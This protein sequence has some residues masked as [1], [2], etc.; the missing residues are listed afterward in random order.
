MND[1]SKTF[2]LE[3]S[4]D[5]SKS[6]SSRASADGP[7]PSDSPAGQ[8]T[9]QFGLA[10]VPVSRFRA[11][12]ADKAM[13]INDISGPLF[14]ASSPSAAL[15]RFLE[16]RLRARLGANGSPLYVLTWSAVDMPSGVPILRLRAAAHRTSGSGSSGW[17]TAEQRKAK[18]P[19]ATGWPSPTSLSPATGEYNEAGDS[20]NLRKIRLLAGWPTPQASAG[21][22]EPAGK[23]GRKL[24]TVA[25]LTGWPT[26][27]T[28]SG[29]RSTSIEKMDA[30]GRTA[31]RTE[32]HGEP[33]ARGQVR[34]L[35]DTESGEA[36]STAAGRLHSEP[37]DGGWMD[38]P[39]PK[40]RQPDQTHEREHGAGDRQAGQGG[41]PSDR[42]LSVWE[43][44][45]L[46][47]CADEKTRVTQPGLCPLAHGVPNRVGRLRAY[48]NAIVPPLAAEFIRAYTAGQA[49]P[50]SVNTFR[51]L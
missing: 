38:N 50:R 9:D 46:I 6:T 8:T 33:G 18:W 15:Q 20:C 13:P 37:A 19:L 29:G 43:E 22:P 7:T 5:T 4:P 44:T 42:R 10:P 49:Q 27:C 40:R 51:S 3:S 11:R 24:S 32:A 48:G 14:T 30:T 34:G 16:S 45:E 41:V 17:P 47:P 26:P 21:G 25:T 2:N 39:S 35:A 36:H 28:P 23:T 1:P 12:D 31:V